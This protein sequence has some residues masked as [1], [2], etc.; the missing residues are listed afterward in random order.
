MARTIQDFKKTFD[1][2]DACYI[3][4]VDG[5]GYMHFLADADSIDLDASDLNDA[6]YTDNLF[7]AVLC[8]YNQAATL[9][10]LC[11]YFFPKHNHR[12]VNIYSH[13]EFL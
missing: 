4:Y 11:N 13:V 10:F 3:F 9:K 1:Q 12:I 7:D 6:I 8:T 2:T 5:A